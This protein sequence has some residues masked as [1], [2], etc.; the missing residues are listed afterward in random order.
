MEK[1]EKLFELN[2]YKT[3]RNVVLKGRSGRKHTLDVLAEKLDKIATF[4]LMVE[5]RT[6][7]R[8]LDKNDVSKVFNVLSDLGLN[9]AVI[10]SLKG[11]SVKAEKLAKELGVELK[12]LN[13]IDEMLS[14]TDMM[15]EE[16]TEKIILLDTI[17]KE[18][19]RDAIKFADDAINFAK[20]IS[21]EI[22]TF[23]YLCLTLLLYS[24][25]FVALSLHF[26]HTPQNFPAAL[27]LLTISGVNILYSLLLWRDYSK[28][29]R[30]HKGLIE[31][32]E[33]LE[34]IKRLAV[35]IAP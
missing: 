15:Q 24:I 26:I 21:K 17:Y 18:L 34:K 14:K 32:R 4:K 25:I 20:D 13:E 3:Q 12:R 29:V 22:K 6:D 19:G 16:D 2:G 7:E 8:L 35:G 11:W 9:K 10:V 27:S 1:I 30:R 33:E 5:C 31:A 23:K 28:T